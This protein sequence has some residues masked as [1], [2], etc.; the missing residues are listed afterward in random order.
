MPVPISAAK[1]I[2]WPA[3]PSARNATL[4]AIQYQLE[5]SQW[6]A[7]EEMQRHQLDQLSLLLAHAY[8]YVPFHRSRLE[9][10]AAQNFVL[11]DLED[12]ARIP[13]I[14]RREI[15]DN[16]EQLVARSMP[17]DHLPLGSGQTSGSTGRP[18][19]YVTTSI[20]KIFARA[21]VL[22]GHLWQDRDLTVSAARILLSSGSDTQNAPDNSKHKEQ[23]WIMAFPGGTLASFDSS[24]TVDEQLRWLKKRKPEWLITYPSNLAAL[25]E[26]AREKGIDLPALKYLSTLGEVVTPRLR[27]LCREVWGLDIADNYS[28]KEVNTIA[29][30]CPD[31]DH[32]HVQSERQLVEVLDE[33]GRPCKPGEIGRVVVT[34]LHN[35]AMPFLRYELGDYAEVGEPCPCGRTLPVLKQILGRTR[36]MLVLPTGEQRWP[37]FIISEWAAMGPISQLQAI[38]NSLT[39][40][41]VRLVL[42]GT[43]EPPEEANLLEAIR[44]DLGGK[45]KVSL[46]YVD[47][48]PRSSN[49]KFEDFISNIGA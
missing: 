8:K 17:E 43:M 23:R 35:Y 38:Q 40:I 6:W 39:E 1:G 18:V 31:H 29:M 16:F 46:T 45:F 32:Y 25:A 41:E 12:L 37:S 47:H 44:R 5:Q 26:T 42:N 27:A 20:T 9:A 30:Q 13:I 15:Q 19:K 21:L 24:R 10:L 49:G 34:D 22:R 14:S 33:Q 36:N 7:P 11:R 28:C 2:K 48:I 3:I 4:L